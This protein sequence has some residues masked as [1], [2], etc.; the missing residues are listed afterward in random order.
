M[1]DLLYCRTKIAW[2]HLRR[3]ASEQLLF[4]E[5]LLLLFGIGHRPNSMMPKPANRSVEAIKPGL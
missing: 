5:L 4:S 2:Y 3:N 1:P